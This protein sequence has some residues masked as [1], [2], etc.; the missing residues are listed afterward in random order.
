MQDLKISL[1]QTPLH[2][3]NTEANLN[4]LEEKIWQIEDKAD[5]IILPEMFN[6]GFTMK[7]E[8]V[9]EVM[10]LTSFRWMKQMA[11]QSGAV[12][13]GSVVIRDGEGFFNRLIWMRPDGSFET[14]DKRHLFRMADEHHTYTA[15]KKRLVCELKGWKI[16]PMICYDL[17]FPVWSRN[18]SDREGKMAFDLLLYVA[19]WPAPRVGAWDILL[20]ARAVENLCYTAGVNRIGEDGNGV[21]YSG[22][23]GVYDPKGETVIFMEDREDVATVTLS[24]SE[25][26]RYRDKFPAYLDADDFTL[27]I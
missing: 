6:S 3:H 11:A 1:I 12:V 17:R 24:G 8:E 9:A 16:C 26:Q 7:A 18:L 2:W 23:S 15:G 25:L 13:T 10:N 21:P 27:S 4:T 5:L 22:H 19:N 20:K 14:Y